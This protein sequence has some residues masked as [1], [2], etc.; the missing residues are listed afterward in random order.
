[1][2]IGACEAGEGFLVGRSIVGGMVREGCC[3]LQ[4]AIEGKEGLQYVC[5]LRFRRACSVK[6]RW[7]GTAEFLAAGTGSEVCTNSIVQFRLF[8][9]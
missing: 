3:C 6:H 7:F 1:M 5:G 2:G 8:L 4:G 9:H